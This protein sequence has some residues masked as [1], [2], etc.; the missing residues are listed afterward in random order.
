MPVLP[1]ICTPARH[2]TAIMWTEQ[3]DP[4]V[5]PINEGSDRVCAIK[6]LSEPPL[7]IVGTYMPTQGAPTGEYEDVLAEVQVI[8]TEHSDCI[9]IWTGDINAATDRLLF[10]LKAICM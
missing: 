1:T 3:L 8:I 6:V 10:V 2:G 4:L 7:L 5:Q 9:P